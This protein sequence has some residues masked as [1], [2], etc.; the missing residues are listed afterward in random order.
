MLKKNY[1]FKQLQFNLD[2]VKQNAFLANKI[3]VI[4]TN[5]NSNTVISAR[6]QIKRNKMSKYN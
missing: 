3:V 2:L 4:C 5:K 1:L 6:I